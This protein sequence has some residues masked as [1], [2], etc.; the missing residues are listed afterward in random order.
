MSRIC[1]LYFQN[2]KIKITDYKSATA[3]DIFKEISAFNFPETLVFK[4]ID[5]IEETDN[6]QWKTL[7]R[8]PLSKNKIIVFFGLIYIIIDAMRKLE[9]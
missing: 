5:F 3:G 8:F 1:N 9:S 2:I 7:Q 6:L 4:N